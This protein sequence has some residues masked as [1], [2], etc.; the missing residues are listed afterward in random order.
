MVDIDSETLFNGAAAVVSTVAVLF[1]VF[2]VDLGLS[3]V[4]KVGL[5][6]AFLALV[7]V[8]TQRTDDYQLTV[9]GYGVI[10]T[11]AVGLFFELT[12]TFDAGEAL[13]VAGLLVIAAVLFSLNRFLDEENHFV[14]GERARNVLGVVVVLVAVVL[15]V[16]VATG[17]LTYEL[18]PQ[19]QIEFDDAQYDEQVVAT[20][21]VTNPTPFPERVDE[22]NYQVCTAGNWSAYRRETPPEEPTRE[23]RAHVYTRVGYNDHVMGYSTRTYPVELNVNGANFEGASFPVRRTETCPDDETGPPYIAIFE[24]SE[25]DRFGRPV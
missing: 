1:F 6:V 21:V 15:V 5:V 7:F 23:V 18:R 12:N 14:S 17:G 8:I 16:D 20:I 10:V 24:S 19:S 2:N 11:S 4:S 3:P 13:T 25:R 22:P 9:L